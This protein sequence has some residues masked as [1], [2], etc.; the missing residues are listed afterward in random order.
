MEPIRLRVLRACE[1]TIVTARG[2]IDLSTAPLFE[3]CLLQEVARGER[4]LVV[5][6]SHTDYLDSSGLA[7]LLRIHK[8]LQEM[9]G[10]L[11]VVGCQPCVLR[12]FQIV[13]FQYLFPIEAFQPRRALSAVA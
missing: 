4:D 12:V 2:D 3:S 11:S 6:L 10:H 7:V 5:N 1:R 9:H 8:K 13:G